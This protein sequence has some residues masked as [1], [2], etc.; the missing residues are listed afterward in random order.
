MG[1]ESAYSSEISYLVPAPVSALQ[2]R[3]AP[4]GQF[5][6]TVSGLT[7]Q[8]YEVQATQDFKTW[9]VIGTVTLG[10]GGSLDFTDT[11]AASFPQRFYRTQETP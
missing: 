9:T 2:I 5:I 6:L 11:N 10:A 3:S 1:Q 7:G 8:T 4:A